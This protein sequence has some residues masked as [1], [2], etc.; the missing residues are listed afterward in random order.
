MCRK[1]FPFWL[2]CGTIRHTYQM[3]RLEL[4]TMITKIL[5][6][7][8]ALTISAYQPVKAE[9]Q[10]EVPLVVPGAKVVTVGQ[11]KIHGTS[12]EGNLEN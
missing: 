3:I 4:L 9:V 1:R 2:R 12:L 11:I 6:V 7:Q 10:T 8:V 5:G